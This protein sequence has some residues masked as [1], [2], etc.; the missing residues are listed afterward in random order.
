MTFHV[1]LNHLYS[2]EKS[3][4]EWIL[5]HTVYGKYLAVSKMLIRH[6]VP[7]AMMPKREPRRHLRMM[8]RK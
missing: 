1:F 3:G 5:L 7:I 4:K 6:Q 2:Y 8:I